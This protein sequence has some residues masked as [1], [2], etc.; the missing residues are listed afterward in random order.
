MSERLALDTLPWQAWKNGAGRTREMAVEPAG[1]GLDDFG[2]RVSVAE[3]AADAPF[4]AYPG[5]DRCITLLRGAGLQLRSDDGR[6]DH[7]LDQLRVPWCFDGG[8]A[9][10]ARLLDGPCLDFNLMTRRGRWQGEVQ[11]VAAPARLPGAEALL[12][13]AADGTPVVDGETLCP[14]EGRLWRTP[15]AGLSIA[16]AGVLLVVRLSRRPSE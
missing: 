10:H 7:R 6:I 8:T 15:V 13:L 5:V 3:V 11:P 4:S 16:G 2:W 14:G 12:M 1:A 9:L